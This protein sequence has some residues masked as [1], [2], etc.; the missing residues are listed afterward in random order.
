MYAWAEI[1]ISPSELAA[2][3]RTLDNQL[4]SGGQTVEPDDDAIVVGYDGGS[5]RSSSIPNCSGLRRS[6]KH[7]QGGRAGF[8]R[9]QG[10]L[11]SLPF[12]ALVTEKPEGGE[13]FD[14]D[15]DYLRHKTKWL[16]LQKTLALVPSVPILRIQRLSAPAASNGETFFG[17]GDPAFRGVPDPPAAR[18]D[19]ASRAMQRRAPND[20]LSFSECGR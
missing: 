4:A 19:A 7:S 6:S 18:S 16:G 1:D 5:G 17:L 13:E 20:G 3:V 15:P 2:E 14:A 8:C 10:A 12:A 11:V 9:R